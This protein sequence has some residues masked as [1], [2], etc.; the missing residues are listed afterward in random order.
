V[1]KD[2]WFNPLM[3]TDR[4]QS[5]EH[6]KSREKRL[7]TDEGKQQIT[8]I[9]NMGKWVFLVVKWPLNTSCVAMWRSSCFLPLPFFFF[10]SHEKSPNI[11]N[12]FSI[13][14]PFDFPLPEKKKNGRFEVRHLAVIDFCTF[15]FFMN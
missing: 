2:L 9:P 12:P 7:M 10:I 6:D 11:L 15:P 4:Q 5:H 3:I 14:F 13:R 8:R 1:K